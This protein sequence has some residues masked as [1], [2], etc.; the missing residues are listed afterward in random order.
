MYGKNVE[1]WLCSGKTDSYDFT[2]EIVNAVGEED[3]ID[4]YV[5]YQATGLRGK[6][7]QCVLEGHT[8]YDWEGHADGCELLERLYELLW[9]DALLIP[10]KNNDGVITG[11]TMN[12]SNTTMR[13]LLKIE[14][15]NGKWSI[16]K[17]VISYVEEKEHIKGAIRKYRGAEEF[18]R[19]AYTIGNFIPVP[20]GCNGPRGIGFT[21]DYW[22]LALNCIYEWYKANRQQL[23]CKVS[24]PKNNA[25][26]D[27]FTKVVLYQDW[28]AAFKSWDDFVVANYMQA[29]VNKAGP[30]DEGTFGRPKELWEGHFAG[31]VLPENKHQFEEFFSN[32]TEWI[33][34]RGVQM[35]SALRK[36]ES[37]S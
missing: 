5:I 35:V 24:W 9:T 17:T 12:S 34:Q 14:M 4:R 36:K 16:G 27:L 18:L 2:K 22:D 33:S 6:E 8:V 19:A 1:E 37:I 20:V 29:F 7:P 31:K 25:L 11:E 21:K 23:K 3:A 26:C 13:E 30:E 10:C 15:R 32:A 28:L